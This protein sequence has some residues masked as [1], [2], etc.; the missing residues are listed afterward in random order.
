MKPLNP[1]MAVVLASAV[2]AS[3]LTAFA[4]DGVVSVPAGVPVAAESANS[5]TRLTTL[6]S[7][8][9]SAAVADVGRR[10]SDFVLKTDD[11]G[12]SFVASGVNE[13]VISAVVERWTKEQAPSDR[14]MFYFVIGTG[15]AVPGWVT[16]DELLSKTLPPKR[17]AEK[18]LRKALERFTKDAKIAAGLEADSTSAFLNTAVAEAK[19]VFDDDREMPAV[20]DSVA[21]NNT[22]ATRVPSTSGTGQ[23]FDGALREYSLQ[24]LYS[25]GAVVKNLSGPNDKNSSTISMKI[26]TKRLPDGTVVNEI[27]IFDITDTSHIVGQRF[28]IDSRD[29]EFVLDDLSPGNKKFELKF[30][31]PDAA[32]NREITFSRPGGEPLKT[33][34]SELFLKRADQAER[35]GNIATVDGKD[36]YVIPQGGAKSGL[37]MFS[38]EV[39]DGRENG[40][41]ARRLIPQL[42]ADVGQ[43]GPGGPNVNIPPGEKGG[44]HLGTTPSGKDFHLV[45]DKNKGGWVVTEG[46]GDMPVA[47]AAAAGTDPAGTSPAGTTPA[48]TTPSADSQT[49]S[50]LKATLFKD[51]EMNADDTAEIAANLKDRYGVVYCTNEIDGRHPIVLVPKTAKTPSQQ[52]NFNAAGLKLNRVRFVDHFLVLQF[53]KQVQYLD[54]LKEDDGGNYTLMGI[55]NVEKRETNAFENKQLFLDALRNY[56]GVTAGSDDARAFTV[57]PERITQTLGNKPVALTGSTPED[58]QT[59]ARYL[60]VMARNNGKSFEIWPNLKTSDVD[61]SG[62]EQY[63]NL[64]GPGNAFAPESSTEDNTPLPADFQAAGSRKAVELKATSTR[65]TVLYVTQDTA[66]APEPKK[67]FLMFRYFADKDGAKTVYRQKPIEVF[68][69]A[70]PYPGDGLQLGSL[71][72]TSAPVL[73]RGNLAYRFISGSSRSKGVLGVFQEAQ[74]T[75]AGQQDSKKNC[76]G[77][78]VWWGVSAAQAATACKDDKF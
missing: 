44:P 1:I 27:G 25:E 70:N 66:G 42:Y 5:I 21:R 63:A 9:E 53:D 56:M 59:H 57:V 61:T 47:P 62:A 3:P 78:V 58:P 29:K 50:A 2:G 67:Y 75:G 31:L 40:G 34:V 15:D 55:V 6:L 14:A 60:M 49:V 48:G 11:A 43:R 76:V 36:Y 38:K 77:S 65:D 73:V 32:G 12:A 16:A 22:T 8:K 33:S 20:D 69:E 7:D 10:V 52:L 28:P 30:G 45:W 18:R 13:E 41:D 19:K 64:S 74:V 23:Q 17:E 26:Y 68:N 71:T 35:M 37:L 39:V 46:A 54:V 72:A 4:T 24:D 51:C